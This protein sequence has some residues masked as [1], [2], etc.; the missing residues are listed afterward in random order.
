MSPRLDP[1]VSMLEFI[2]RSHDACCLTNDGLFWIFSLVLGKKS[3]SV[4]M[5]RYNVEKASATLEPASTSG[6]LSG[7]LKETVS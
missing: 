3:T 2:I 4:R 1:T 7:H 5:K 6:R